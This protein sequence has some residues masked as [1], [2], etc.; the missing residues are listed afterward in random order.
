MGKYTQEFRFDSLASMARAVQQ[1]PQ[2]WGQSGGSRASR[3]TMPNFWHFDTFADACSAAIN[4]WPAGRA[5]IGQAFHVV[6]GNAKRRNKTRLD[7]A[8]YMVSAPDYLAGSQFCMVQDCPSDK[9]RE[10]YG[11]VVRIAFHYGTPGYVDQEDYLFR[12]AAL[13][14]LVDSLEANGYSVEL[15]AVKFTTQTRGSEHMQHYCETRIKEAGQPLDLDSIAFAMLAPDM[16]RR[17]NF[18]CMES[19]MPKFQV[20]GRSQPLPAEERARFGLYFC[21]MEGHHNSIERA[22]ELVFAEARAQMPE[23]FADDF[24]QTQAA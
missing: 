9:F 22:R 24:T 7:V 18:A 1:M 5:R 12:G 6:S 11:R 23:L 21:R 15:D 2:L 20:H 10:G 19:Q 17:L 3:S 4:G 16:A 8:G 14:A 13:L